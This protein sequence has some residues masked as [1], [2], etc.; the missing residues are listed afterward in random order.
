ML[1]PVLDRFTLK[2]SSTPTMAS[3]IVPLCPSTP[4]TGG[5]LI[6]SV[7]VMAVSWTLELV[8]AALRVGVA[9]TG[10]DRLPETEYSLAGPCTV[11]VL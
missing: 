5:M 9:V 3:K 4:S 1:L 7:W 10:M 6:T 8:C 2:D 11:R